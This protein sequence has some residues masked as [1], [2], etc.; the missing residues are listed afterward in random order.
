[1]SSPSAFPV[2][3]A[4]KRFWPIIF[5]ALLPLIPL[6]KVILSGEAIGPFDQIRQMAPWNGAKPS[7]PWDVLQADGVLQFFV[8]RDLVGV[9][10]PRPLPQGGAA[11]R[12]DPCR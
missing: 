9:I 7:Q 8:W 12:H 2:P 11:K 6:S 4:I 1:M 10:R 5:L 3:A